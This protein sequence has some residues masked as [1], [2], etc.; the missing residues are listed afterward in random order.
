MPACQPPRTQNKKEKPCIDTNARQKEKSLGELPDFYVL[1][2]FFVATFSQHQHNFQPFLCY[3]KTNKRDKPFGVLI[4]SPLSCAY[5][6]QQKAQHS[7]CAFCFLFC[8]LIFGVKCRIFPH[9]YQL[10]I[11][12]VYFS[13]CLLDLAK[14]KN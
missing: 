4:S 3:Y 8:M 9:F 5:H 7:R 13:Y 12:T 2:L 10:F 6:L 14:P 11:Y 1:V